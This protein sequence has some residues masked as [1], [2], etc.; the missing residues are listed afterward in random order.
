MPDVTVAAVH[1][2]AIDK[3]KHCDEEEEEDA[4]CPMAD[5]VVVHTDSDEVMTTHG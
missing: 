2:I 5:V 1:D 4:N 3:Q